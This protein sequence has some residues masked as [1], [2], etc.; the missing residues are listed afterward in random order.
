MNEQ[1]KTDGVFN[2]SE[3]GNGE[4]LPPIKEGIY[5]AIFLGYR[6]SEPKEVGGKK[7]DKAICWLFKITEGEFANRTIDN[8]GGY[9]PTKNNTSGKILMGLSAGKIQCDISHFVNKP[10]KVVAQKNNNGRVVVSMVMAA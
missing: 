1:I 8:Y 6:E 3:G 9:N 5:S 10:Y 2:V 7:L 4:K